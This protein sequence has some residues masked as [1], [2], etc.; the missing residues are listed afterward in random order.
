MGPLVCPPASAQLV[1]SSPGL[2]GLLQRSWPRTTARWQHRP[3]PLRQQGHRKWQRRRW[4][5]RASASL[6]AALT[7]AGAVLVGAAALILVL[8]AIPLLLVSP[9]TL[10]G[11]G[12][13]P[14][15]KTLLGAHPSCGLCRRRQRQFRA[16]P[17]PAIACPASRCLTPQAQAQESARAARQAR[18][19]LAALEQEIPETAA[20]LR[21]GGL[22]LADC[23]NEMSGLR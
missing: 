23:I 16:E 11:A 8:S 15:P 6:A 20:T 3:P 18:H 17:Q 5:C 19:T 22:E 21:L 2:P 1:R 13:S 7:A 4:V 14:A 9:C 12:Q 10:A